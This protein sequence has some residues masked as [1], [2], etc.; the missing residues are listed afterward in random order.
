M[1]KPFL[2]WPGGKSEEVSIIRQY[3]PETITNYIEPFLGGGACFLSLD[4]DQY[5]QAYVNDLSHELIHLYELIQARNEAFYQSLLDIW[6]FWSFS[7]QFF[8]ENEARFIDM[9][10]RYRE[11]TVSDE[12]LKSEVT[13][14]ID[15]QSATFIDRIPAALGTSRHVAISEIKKSIYSKIKNIKRKEVKT[16]LLPF[17]DYASNLESGVR[18]GVYTFY[19]YVYNNPELHNH[20]VTMHS[21]LF[22]YIREFCYSSMFR[23]NNAGEF[24]VPY[25]G[26]S[27]NKKN[28]LAKIQYLQ[29]EHLLTSISRAQF[30][31][32]DF[33]QFLRDIPVTENDF[34]FLDPPYDGG[35]STYAQNEFMQADQ[36]R[37]ANYLIHECT[38]NFMLI[39]KNTSF[40]ASLYEDQPNVQIVGFDKDYKVSFMDRND[41]KVLH[42]LIKN[43]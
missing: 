28:F 40:I 5:E 2:K 22:F 33:E 1:T 16:G 19:R 39:I 34:I 14:F 23:Y 13:E 12:A 24:N 17:E 7:G 11:G 36:I 25:G 20:S 3:L 30:Y 10:V 26:L 35:F 38:A 8:Q 32:I 43:Y 41:K 42:L 18:A 6:N 9:Y 27:Y 31:N 21:A 37:L 15:A 29:N 4:P